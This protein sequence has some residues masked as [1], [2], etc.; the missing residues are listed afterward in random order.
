[1]SKKI[2]FGL[3]F[4]VIIAIS[5]IIIL[6]SVILSCFFIAGQTLSL[7]GSIENR[8]I[9]LANSL[10]TSSEY[11]VTTNSKEF[12]SHLTR[13]TLKEE[14]VLY[15]II[16]DV[17]GNPLALE[18]ISNENI[19]KY[20]FS[21]PI[22]TTTI[23]KL[24][25]EKLKK[26]TGTIQKVG[27]F[28]DITVPISSYEYNPVSAFNLMN[29]KIDAPIAS[30]DEDNYNVPVN[31]KYDKETVVGAVRIGLTLDRIN[32]Q[33]EKM[34]TSI[35]FLTFIVILAGIIISF[36]LVKIILTPIRELIL[37]TKKVSAGDLE[38]RVSISSK[39]EFGELANSFNSMANDMEI[40]VK[41][42]NIEKRELM[43]LKVAFEQRSN[44][45]EETLKK[46]QIMQQDLV[47][48]EKFATVGRLASSVAHELRNPLAA[49][50]NISYFLSRMHNF[51]DDKSKT[52]VKMLSDEV[53]RANKI[54]TEL[55]DYSRIKKLTKLEIEIVPFI[56]KVI[57]EVPMPKNVKLIT[58]LEDFKV[59]LDP[60]K[61][62]QVLINLITNARDAMPPNKE[63][64]IKITTS[65]TNDF[66]QI[67]IEDNAC[68][69]SEETL[70]H[71]F[72]PLFTTKLKGIGLGLPIA[73]E[74]IDAH[75][76]KIIV[77]S[78]KDIGTTFKIELPL[79]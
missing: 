48:A 10:A 49:I 4:K 38:Y 31:I 69:M 23:K 70:S 66:C 50:K 36:F 75:M 8:A 26:Y 13:N 24:E 55:L 39:D 65:K 43:R 71:L 57:P 16:Y 51:A 6:T 25:K 79:Q 18:T 34:T 64:Q 77:T 3:N 15:S 47:R 59:M 68:G 21:T 11:G 22:E 67:S 40:H 60:D 28:I 42:L 35:V 30:Y 53:L 1:M 54:I 12:L 52:M 5:S 37:G 27:D 29:S 73:K 58:Q 19:E 46:V 32:Y 63:G 44:E 72:E 17:N 61:I 14:D 2:S 62:T 9:I 33:I 45:L 74:I 56:N 20:I 78:K 41:E 76:G 7:K